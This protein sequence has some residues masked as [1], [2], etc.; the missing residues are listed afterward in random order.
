MEGFNKKGQTINSQKQ[1]CV[2]NVREY[3]EKEKNNGGPLLPLSNVVQRTA[4]AVKISNRT[5]IKISKK[6]KLSTPGKLRPRKKP[7]TE[8]DD[9]SADAIRRHVYGYYSRGEFPTLKKLLSSLTEAG[10]FHGKT[11]KSLQNMLHKLNF[12]FQKY[13]SRAVLM[14]TRLIVNWRV[15]FLRKV[16]NIDWK[17]IVFIDETWV[18]ANHCMKKAWTDNSVPGTPR[19]PLGKGGRLIVCHAGNMDG[20]IPGALLLFKSKS[21]GDYHEEMDATR[22]KSWF[23]DSLLPNI[24]E[25]SF[26]IMDNA[27]YHSVQIDRQPTT[28]TKKADIINWLKL[29]NIPC[30]EDL[31]KSELLELVKLSNHVTR[32]EIDEIA[33]NRGH[34]VIRIP[35]YHCQYNAIEMIWA[36]VKG[37]VAANNK[38]QGLKVVE[39]LL[40]EGI[41]HIT[42]ETWISVVEHTRKLCED[43]WVK[44]GVREE[45]V[46]Q[47]I[48]NIGPTDSED[49]DSDDCNFSDDDTVSTENIPGPSITS[50]REIMEELG[51]AELPETILQYEQY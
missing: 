44:E 6:E 29:K 21:T 3:F 12:K 30:S 23:T 10:L 26:I 20:F 1:Q 46:E 25:G 40:R 19:A 34:T 36:N 9:F 42:R 4:D 38:F 47:M 28:A 16:R 15:Q 11:I 37:Y 13:S 31:L 32:Y 8:V 33:N 48:I 50:T 27:S 5:V 39:K 17:K 43:D 22:F 7:V 51:V 24:E 14:E 2:L 35:P 41:E 49:E 18:N 45:N